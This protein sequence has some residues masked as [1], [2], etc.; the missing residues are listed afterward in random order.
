[1]K[2]IILIGM[3]GCG[4]STVGK[5]LAKL[6]SRIFIDTDTMIENRTGKK[7]SELFSEY[8][9]DGFRKIE[10][11]VFKEAVKTKN[12]IIATGGGIV[13]VPSNYDIATCGIIVFVDRPLDNI[14]SD[15]K[16]DKRPLL[17]N[18]PKKLSELYDKRFD[19]YMRW[20]DI[21]IIN[22]KSLSDAIKKILNGV[23]TYEN[24]GD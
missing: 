6:G 21:H 17:K 8:G 16:T 9:E 18:S 10:S 22:D 3:P 2:N 15:I 5:H 11:E 1:M 20:A 13:T 23:N 14:S 24:N 4:K 7:I 19:E 12:A